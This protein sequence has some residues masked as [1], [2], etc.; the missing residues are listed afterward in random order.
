MI[1]LDLESA[2]KVLAA[3][4]FSVLVGARV[5]VFEPGRAVLA[6]DIRGDLKQ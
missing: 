3:Q 4:P 6:L 1:T 5:A 2:R